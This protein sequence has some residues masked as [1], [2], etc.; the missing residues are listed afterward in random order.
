LPSCEVASEQ[1][2]PVTGAAHVNGPLDYPDKPPVG[3]DHNPCW[4]R[5][6]VYER[7]LSTERWVHNLEHGGVVFLF[8][9]DG[10]CASEVLAMANVVN[11]NPQA[12][13]TPY[14][15]LPTRF[16]V[17]AWGVRLTSDCFDLARFQ[18]FY[19]EHVGHGL[20]QVSSNPP[21]SCG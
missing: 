10:D 19:D 5:W 9:C 15:A 13:L 4:A 2:V 1:V 14:A 11:T 16:A 18:R 7:E 12:I 21:S 3:G 17:V 20:E 6:S 8:R